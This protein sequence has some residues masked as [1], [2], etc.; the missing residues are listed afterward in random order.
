MTGVQTCAL[1]IYGGH[2]AE[3]DSDE[4]AAYGHRMDLQ[5]SHFMEDKEHD[6]DADPSHDDHS[7]VGEILR[8]RRKKRAGF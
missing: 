3:E 6:V 4:E 8:D 1:P 7:L 2:V 5:R